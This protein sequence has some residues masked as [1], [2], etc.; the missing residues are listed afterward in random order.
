MS[1]NVLFQGYMQIDT[2]DYS[3]CPAKSRQD[4]VRQH[5]VIREIG[6]LQP[7]IICLQEVGDSKKWD[8]SLQ[9]IGYDSIFFRSGKPDYIAIAVHSERFRIR[10][11]HGLPFELHPYHDEYKQVALLAVV[12]P[13]YGSAKGMP[14]LV[15]NTHLVFN[16]NRGDVKLLQVQLIFR[17]I[18]IAL[19]SLP[20]NTPVI[21]GGDLNSTPQ[22][23]ICR[24]ILEG[25]LDT[26][27][28]DRKLADGQMFE[29]IRHPK[30]PEGLTVPTAATDLSLSFHSISPQD[31]GTIARHDLRFQSA[32]KYSPADATQFHSDFY[33]V[34]DHM[35]FTPKQLTVTGL[36]SLP[37]PQNLSRFQGLPTADF[38]SDHL[39][40]LV[41]FAWSAPVL[42][43]TSA[44]APLTHNAET[45]DFAD[46][47]RWAATL[48]RQKVRPKPANVQTS[49]KSQKAEKPP[50][51]TS[52]ARSMVG[53]P[54]YVAPSH[55]PL[56][57]TQEQLQ[58]PRVAVA[59]A[60]EDSDFPR[61]DIQHS[62]SSDSVLGEVYVPDVGFGVNY[63]DVF[64]TTITAAGA[65]KPMRGIRRRGKKK[66]GQGGNRAQ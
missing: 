9:S 42:K 64:K 5:N 51:A 66:K 6:Q 21:F 49:S 12:E 32:Y 28:V 57:G 35:F 26:S 24:F 1:W 13:L 18:S 47:I 50:V 36:L 8:S 65:T 2:L 25:Q 40:L 46:V 56:A 11:Y 58:G 20:P 30:K 54:A 45:K 39:Q 22:S 62:L 60:A 7:D 61:L 31:S 10:S 34:V 52:P 29:N 37:I 14:I 16:K 17:A 44:S 41:E 38:G 15:V 48:P 59:V 27:K 4:H 3:Y 33:G 55:A 19:A 23:S 53:P 63:R 43:S